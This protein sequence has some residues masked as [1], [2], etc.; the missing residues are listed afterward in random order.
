MEKLHFKTNIN[1][2][3]CVAK[4]AERLVILVPPCLNGLT[5]RA[6]YLMYGLCFYGQLH[7][8]LIL[9]HPTRTAFML[10]CRPNKRS[11]DSRCILIAACIISQKN[12]VLSFSFI[13][14]LWSFLALLNQ[15][16]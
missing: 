12:S 15:L 3:G 6:R 5:T 10:M 14:F 8:D 7:F 9:F 13:N 16:Q 11:C 4:V 1:C 2:G